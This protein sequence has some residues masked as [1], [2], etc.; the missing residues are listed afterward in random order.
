MADLI[1]GNTQLGPTKQDVIAAVVQ[2]ELAFAAKLM[3]YVTDVSV[4]A[5]KGAKSISFPKLTSFSVVNR[6]S[7]VQGDASVLTSAV[8]TIQLSFNAYVAW[9]IDSMDETQSTIEAQVAFAQRAASALGRYVDTQILACA[10]ADAGLDVG[11][12]PITRDLILD[13][14]E[15]VLGTGQANMDQLV[16]VVGVDQEKEM[17]KISEFSQAQVYGGAVIPSGVIGKVYGMPV[18]VHSGVAAGHAHL[19]EKGGIAVGFQKS[20]AMSVQ[21]ANEFGVGAMRSAMDQLFGV[22]S[23]QQAVNGAAAGK[24]PLIAYL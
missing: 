20:P 1:T 18:L 14:R 6:A 16:L 9:I 2:R 17:L 24:S 23:L 8:D 19:W 7:G 21:P 22:D 5:A 12:A 13:M 15:Y 3:P 10:A 4:F 11:A